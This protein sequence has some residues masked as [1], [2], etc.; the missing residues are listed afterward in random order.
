MILLWLLH[1]IFSVTITQP[2][3]I[4][5]LLYLYQVFYDFFDA[6]IPESPACLHLN[7]ACSLEV[8]RFRVEIDP[9]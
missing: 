2:W 3:I 5:S 4:A 1:D 9:C 7:Y 8:E 6:C